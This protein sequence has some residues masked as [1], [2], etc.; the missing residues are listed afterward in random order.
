[1]TTQIQQQSSCEWLTPEQIDTL[2]QPLDEQVKQAKLRA[3]RLD[4]ARDGQE[5]A[6]LLAACEVTVIKS[7]ED[8][9]KI[10]EH[11]TALESRMVATQ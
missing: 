2:N 3:Q 7:A 4:L 8:V 9:A 6:N 10:H 11:M 5:W 1:M